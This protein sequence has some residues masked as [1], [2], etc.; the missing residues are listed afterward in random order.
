MRQTG[1]SDTL[2][3][4]LIC[5]PYGLYLMWKRSC[6]W[7]LA[8]K[9]L[10]TLAIAALIVG[11][12]L[13]PEPAPKLKTS[14]TLVEAEPNAEIFGPDAPAGYDPSQYTVAEGGQD[15]IA[16]VEEDDTVYVYVSAS[17]GSTYYHMSDCK[18]AFASSPRV[19]LYEAYIMGYNRPCGLCN[20]PLYEPAAVTTGGA[21]Q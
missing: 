12:A 14:V 19:T 21:A 7:N 16:V 13:I 10:V 9:G 8:V 18:Y 6:Q 2:K 15:L 3:W 17:E 1:R 20:P 4:L 5:F 11:V